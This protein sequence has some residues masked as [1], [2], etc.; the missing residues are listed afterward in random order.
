MLAWLRREAYIFSA[1]MVGMLVPIAIAVAFCALISVL[2]Q[3]CM[4]VD[5]DCKNQQVKVRR[6][7]SEHDAANAARSALDG[8][9]AFTDK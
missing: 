8:C 7:A 3:G 2:V 9:R 6:A 4:Q 1:E 5:V